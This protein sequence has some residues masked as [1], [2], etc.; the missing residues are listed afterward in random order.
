MLKSALKIMRRSDCLCKIKRNQGWL[1]IFAQHCIY[2][3]INIYFCNVNSTAPL[4]SSQAALN[5]HQQVSEGHDVDLSALVGRAVVTHGRLSCHV[6]A[7]C[8]GE[9][10]CSCLD[11]LRLQRIE[12][13][14]RRGKCRAVTN[15]TSSVFA[16]VKASSSSSG[17]SMAHV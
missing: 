2:L 13:Y 5:K 16:P 8:N 17:N 7:A 12:T 3:P 6:T 9:E 11:V 4:S 1:K 14:P 10:V 15:E